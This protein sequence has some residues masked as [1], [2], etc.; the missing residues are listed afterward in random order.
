MKIIKRNKRAAFDYFLIQQF[1][2]GIILTGPEVK[3]VKAGNIELAESFVRFEGEEVF[4][5]NANISKTIYGEI[6]PTRERKLLLHKKEIDELKRALKQKGLTVIPV[7]I[8]LERGLIKVE[9]AVGRGKK[10]YDKRE[11]IK[12]RENDVIMRKVASGKY[13]ARKSGII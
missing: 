2:A 6:T 4:L 9:I 3:A 7:A 10:N 13:Q 12:K 1:S 8:G 5:W 11:T